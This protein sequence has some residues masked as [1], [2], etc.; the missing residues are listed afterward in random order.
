M[1]VPQMSQVPGVDQATE[2]LKAV[3]H[4]LGDAEGEQAPRALLAVQSCDL[5]DDLL[6]AA[7]PG[8]RSKP[9]TLDPAILK[10]ARAVQ[11]LFT[12][13]S[14]L[15]F[16]RA[17][18]TG[19]A[20]MKLGMNADGTSRW[21]APLFLLSD[22]VS[23]GL[24]AGAHQAA[25]LF[26]VISEQAAD[27]LR[28]QGR[29]GN[30]AAEKHLTVSKFRTAGSTLTTSSPLPDVVVLSHAEGLLVDVP[31]F[32]AGG[33]EVDTMKNGEVYG[34]HVAEQG[35]QAILGGAVPC[36]PEF[37]LLHKRLNEA[38]ASQ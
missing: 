2:S 27:Q 7:T 8:G 11:F 28:S 1:K 29:L 35:P 6:S 15:V 23:L 37:V 10:Q 17:T 22:S 30:T 25:T 36:P 12:Q 24:T 16:G 5:L 31:L 21:S 13:K 26:C 32:T 4:A 3:A 18:T 9:R 14:G 20:L 19:V 38:M 34:Q 33:L